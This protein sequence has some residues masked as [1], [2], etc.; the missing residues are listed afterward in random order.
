MIKCF[1]DDRHEDGFMTEVPA[2]Q[3]LLNDK[4]LSDSFNTSSA[5]ESAKS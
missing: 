2:G 5:D 3:Q 1:T 4:E